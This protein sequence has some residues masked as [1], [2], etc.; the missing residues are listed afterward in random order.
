[1]TFNVLEDFSVETPEGLINLKQGQIIK[2]IVDEAIPIIE[3]GIIKPVKK[4]AYRVY[5]NILEANLW[6]VDTDE[7][8]K[9]SRS[10]GI[11]AGAPIYTQCEIQELKKLPN[12]DLKEIHMVKE[13]F[14]NSI[15][16]E[17]KKNDE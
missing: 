3:A 15:I 6:V 10:K 5:S 11:G 17:V 12:E 4:V 2:L 16:E 14:L 1:M 9:S 7:D 13:I 8:I